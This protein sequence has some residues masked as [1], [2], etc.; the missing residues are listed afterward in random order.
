M[1]LISGYAIA[2]FDCFYHIFTKGRICMI[3]GWWKKLIFFLG[4]KK[5]C[6]WH[7]PV[8]KK[9]WSSRICSC[10]LR[11]FT[12][13]C[14]SVHPSVRHTLIFFFV[15]AV[16]DPN[17]QVTSNTA[18]AHPYPTGLAVYP[19]LFC[20]ASEVEIKLWE[21]MEACGLQVLILKG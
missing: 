11:D 8:A 21:A 13:L 1:C 16:F 15:F 5:N 18:S 14:W 4:G 9:G 17:D 2:R 12:P 19:A 20:N 6:L 7:F 10:V 3:V